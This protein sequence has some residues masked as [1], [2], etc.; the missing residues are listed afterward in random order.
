[1]S[2]KE[3]AT[4]ILGKQLLSLTGKV[5]DEF[6]EE[7]KQ[8]I[9]NNILEYQVEEYKRN[10]LSK[11]I[12]HRAAPQKLSDFYQPLFIRKV[13]YWG[14]HQYGYEQRI[15]T[16]SIKKLF[17]DIKKLH[18]AHQFITILG[19]AGS[20][21]STLIKSSYICTVVRPEDP[22]SGVAGLVRQRRRGL[23]HAARP[24]GRSAFLRYSD[25]GAERRGVLAD[26]PR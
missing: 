19:S 20:G 18:K 10:S 14:Y 24:S 12:I 8:T 5:L 15:A 16:D 26:A 17:S 11:T 6:A 21:K 3:L 1:M 25:A 4:S 22:L 23:R 9:N 13:S 2:F 7:I